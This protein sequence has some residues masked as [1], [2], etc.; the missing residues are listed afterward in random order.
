[1]HKSE[2]FWTVTNSSKQN[3]S[4]CA[5]FKWI[6]TR[7]ESLIIKLQI[8]CIL[9]RIR[10]LWGVPRKRCS[11][12]MQQIYRKTPMPKCDFNKVA[13]QIYWNR[14]LAWCSPVNL[15]HIFRTPFLKNI[16]VWLLTILVRP[17]SNYLDIS[18]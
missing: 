16:T 7:L 13:K 5:S 18:V 6:C 4:N 8:S 2:F 17:R 14:T 11:E 12:K 1:M 15:L 10:P 3:C 9:S